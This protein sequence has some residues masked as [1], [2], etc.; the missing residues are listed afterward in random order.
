[1]KHWALISGKRAQICYL[2]I[3]ER[4][5]LSRK[6][7]ENEIDFKLS[8]GIPRRKMILHNKPCFFQVQKT[9]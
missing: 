6:I 5:S 2:E 1:M 9:C 4:A 8:E 7:C 3:F